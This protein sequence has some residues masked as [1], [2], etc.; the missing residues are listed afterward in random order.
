[1]DRQAD[2]RWP[3]ID[4]LVTA[5][6]KALKRYAYLLCGSSHGADDLVQEALTRVLSRRMP[7]DPQELEKYVRRVI[8][9]IVVDEARRTVRWGRLLPWVS[10]RDEVMD[11][12]GEIVERVALAEVLAALAPRQRACVVLRYYEDLPVDEIAALL[13]CGE[14]TVKS[15][16]HDARR[17]LARRW[18]VPAGERT[19]IAKGDAR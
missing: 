17:V 9:N 3:A 18:D 4:A 7:T 10:A 16:L 2:R 6:S 11:R 19:G 13:G 5:R 12:S 8:V 15:Q 1:M 14:G